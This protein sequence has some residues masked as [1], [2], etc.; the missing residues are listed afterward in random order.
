MRGN[1]SWMSK[2]GG[3]KPPACKQVKLGAHKAQVEKKMSCGAEWLMHM[4]FEGTEG[5]S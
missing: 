3:A 2:K 1:E 5:V 4:K